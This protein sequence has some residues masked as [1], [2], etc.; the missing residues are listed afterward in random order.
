M[1]NNAASTRNHSVSATQQV[2]IGS[3]DGIRHTPHAS[4]EG[5]CAGMES[6][7]AWQMSNIYE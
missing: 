7:D 1:K 6:L 3:D 5:I 4:T 2:C